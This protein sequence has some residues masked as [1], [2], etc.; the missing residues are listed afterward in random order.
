MATELTE[1]TPLA[2]RWHVRKTNA[3]CGN[4]VTGALYINGERMDAVTLA[5]N[6]TTGVTRTFFANVKVGDKIDLI[7]S[8]RGTDNGDADGCDGSANSW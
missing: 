5:F 1:T 2:L 4:G 7:L 6:N 3:G 8:P